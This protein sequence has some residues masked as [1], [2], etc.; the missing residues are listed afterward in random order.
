M[1]TKN[2]HLTTTAALVAVIALAIGMTAGTAPVV[3]SADSGPTVLTGWGSDSSG[4][5]SGAAAAIG[6]GA[7]AS[8]SVSGSHE[9]ALLTDGTVADWDGPDDSDT[10]ASVIG[11]NTVT[12]VSAGPEYGL[13]LLANGTVVGWG[14]DQLSL[15]SGA[16]AAIS[17]ATTD[18]ATV[19]QISAGP[20]NALALLSDGTV[21]GWG[22]NS[23]GQSVTQHFPAGLVK[24]IVAAGTSSFAVFND[25]SVS[26]WGF[27]TPMSAAIGSN[28]VESISASNTHFVAL[29]DNGSAVAWGFDLGGT[30]ASCLAGIN[31]DDTATAVAAGYDFSTLLLADGS[32][33]SCGDNSVTSVTDPMGAGAATAIAAGDGTVFALGIAPTISI[34]NGQDISAG[35]IAPG[36]RIII[37][38]SDFRSGL[39]ETESIDGTQYATATTASDGSLSTYDALPTLKAGTHT[40]TIVVGTQ[41]FT[42]TLH[43][44]VGF[45]TVTPTITGTAKVGDTLQLHTG[46]WSTD[47][48]FAYEWLRSGKAITDAVGTEYLL[49]AADAGKKITVKVTGTPYG[50]ASSVKPVSKTSA[51]TATVADGTLNPIQPDIE[52][53]AKVGT[54]LTALPGN[55]SPG[56]LTFGYQWFANG[57]AIKGATKFQYLLP[58]SVAGKQLT[59]EVTGKETGYVSQTLL[60]QATD[61]AAVGDLIVGN[62]MTT[63]TAVV[64]SKLT[65]LE[66]V[67]GKGVTSSYQ[68]LR[69]GVP[70]MGAKS[71]SYTVTTA[72]REHRLSLQVNGYEAGY[73]G[74]SN[75]SGQTATVMTGSTP[76]ITGTAKVGSTLT[77]SPGTW[78]PDVGL[79]FD[80]LRI[81]GKTVTV[82]KSTPDNGSVPPPTDT[83]V[84]TAADKGKMIEVRVTGIQGGYDS[85]ILTSK[86]T[87]KIG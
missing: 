71:S 46:T 8:I 40:L 24:Q 75:V 54:T 6:S 22:S 11:N 84:L 55:W 9:V 30:V 31:P 74:A 47:T 16:A 69:N 2:L 59:V 13:A 29:L 5:I 21:V 19:T 4:Q 23:N 73:L 57:T 63:E 68:W 17:A 39:A 25:G 14:D 67:F 85:A 3:A 43:I 15:I 37:R 12:Q 26:T 28:K 86:A 7:V 1:R 62:V 76:T 87:K 53:T 58:G 64:G 20:L 42:Y 70:I 33:V 45:T 38:G 77:A 56:N 27:A 72:D 18:G 83:Y 80:W 78:T 35:T 51:S 49:K 34:N 41:T 82:V 10:P 65:L 50:F 66:P 81:S 60:S 36:S 44:A 61:F 79:T 52:G 48:S 32:V